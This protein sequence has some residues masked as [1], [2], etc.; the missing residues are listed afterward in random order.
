MAA[1]LGL[2]LQAQPTPEFTSY[3]VVVRKIKAETEPDANALR[4]VVDAALGDTWIIE[5]N[6]NN[7]F[8]NEL[9]PPAKHAGWRARPAAEDSQP[10]CGWDSIGWTQPKCSPVLSRS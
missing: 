4:R 9:K 8:E 3:R 5:P 10:R 6:K 2:N 7:A 1:I